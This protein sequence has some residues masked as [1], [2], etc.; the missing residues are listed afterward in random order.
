MNELKMKVEIKKSGPTA[1][2]DYLDLR[3]QNK[4]YFKFK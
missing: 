3:I 2:L 1:L 4:V